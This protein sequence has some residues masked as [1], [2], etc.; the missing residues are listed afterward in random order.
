MVIQM[1]ESDLDRERPQLVDFNRYRY[2]R[3]KMEVS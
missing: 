3:S 1:K 2:G